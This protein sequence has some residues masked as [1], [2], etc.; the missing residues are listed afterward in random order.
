MDARVRRSLRDGDDVQLVMEL[1]RAGEL[2]PAEC[3]LVDLLALEEEPRLDLETVFSWAF[4][5]LSVGGGRGKEVRRHLAGGYRAVAAAVLKP[6]L[7]E[8]RH[9]YSQLDASLC[10]A[11]RCFAAGGAEADRVSEETSILEGARLRSQ[12]NSRLRIGVDAVRILW[13]APGAVPGILR[14][15]M[16]RMATQLSLQKTRR[17]FRSGV[18]S[19]L[20]QRDPEASGSDLV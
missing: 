19:E 16:E 4:P 7:R 1:R 18:L 20:V 6:W 12:P 9:I 2:S 17:L 8:D 14:H 15:S 3:E 11:A 10:E 13:Q 5:D